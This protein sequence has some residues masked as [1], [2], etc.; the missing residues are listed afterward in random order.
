MSVDAQ[1]DALGGLSLKSPPDLPDVADD[2]PE[3]VSDG[4]SAVGSSVS[5]S[6]KNTIE[7]NAEM[8]KN[9]MIVIQQLQEKVIYLHCFTINSLTYIYFRLRCWRNRCPHHLQTHRPLHLFRLL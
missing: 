4:G 6:S 9:G 7:I 1:A 3:Y 5:K 8:A 2:L